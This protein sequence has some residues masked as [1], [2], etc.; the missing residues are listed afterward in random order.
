MDSTKSLEVSSVN[1]HVLFVPK[2]SGPLQDLKEL[3]V[4]NRYRKI[5]LQKSETIL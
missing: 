5:L 2:L 3:P 1:S 4:I